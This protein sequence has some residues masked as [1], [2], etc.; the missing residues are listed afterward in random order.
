MG[1]L[2]RIVRT[3]CPLWGVSAARPSH[4]VRRRRAP[5]LPR[6]A[7]PPSGA[8]LARRTARHPSAWLLG[9]QLTAVVAYPFLDQTRVGAAVLGVISMVAVGLAIGVVRSTPALSV[10]AVAVGLPAV[11]MTLVEAA[12]PQTEWVA[13]VSA[14]LH[15]PFYFYVAYSTIKYLFHDDR[16]TTDELYAIGAAFTVV[17]WGFAYLYV[18]VDILFP[19]SIEPVSDSGAGRFFDMLFLSFTTLTSVGLSD[20]LPV[21]D[22]A[23]SVVILEQVSGVLYVA[24]VISRLVAMAVRTR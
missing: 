2:W 11:V 24:M 17:A 9:A 16:V 20:I 19:G 23:R 4:P 8:T 3:S 15:A 22:H 12:T 10:I 14:L 1:L 6:V 13:L 7:H 18:I 21:G 5:R